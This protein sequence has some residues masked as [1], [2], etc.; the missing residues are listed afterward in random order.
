MSD[1]VTTSTLVRMKQ[2]GRKIASLTA[3]DYLTARMLDQC[4]IDMILVGDS[5]AMVF[6]GYEN[7]LPI[8]MEAMLY[9]TAAVKRGVNAGRFLKESGAE[10]VKLE[11]GR[12]AAP[13]VKN[14]VE[15]GIPVMGHL[16]LTPQSVHKFGGYKLQA[17]DKESAERLLTAAKAL[18]AAGCFAI[19]LEKIP[20]QVARRVS[21]ALAIPTIGIGAG[22]HCDGQILV[23]DDMD[24]RFEDFTPKF[25]RRYAEIAKAMTSTTCARARS[26][27]WPKA[28]RTRNNRSR[29][30]ETN[31][32][33]LRSKQSRNL[34]RF[35][36]CGEESCSR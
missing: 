21:E 1:K 12:V 14:L 35:A 33:P 28:S 27:R 20:H 34:D 22:P 36:C 19:V 24:G 17:R 13:I 11:G 29:H 25:V 18:E 2:Q 15:R 6:A 26:R 32:M 23:V 4:G 31:A 3:Y 9:H 10:A 16:G 8:T 5:A 30:R 7:T